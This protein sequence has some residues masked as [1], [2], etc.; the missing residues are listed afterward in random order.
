M[1]SCSS[2]TRG[3][4]AARTSAGEIVLLADQD[5]TL[6]DRDQI[7][8][9][10]GLDDR[11]L[12]P[13]RRPAH[14]PGPYALQAAIAA[15]HARPPTALRPTGPGSA[16]STT[17]CVLVEPSPVVALNRAVALAMAEGPD[18]GLEE[19]DAIEGLD[20]YL[21]LPLRPRRPAGAGRP[22]GR[23]AA[24]FT[25]ALE[26]ATSPVERALLERRLA[27]LE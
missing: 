3:A 4:R 19:I 9:G 12:G 20:A 21:H 22:P 16:T 18:G 24:A 7:I 13:A 10:V 25:R 17:G 5:R 14:P 2:T 23:R 15:E 8:E 6:W 26:L 27:A 11:A 1:R